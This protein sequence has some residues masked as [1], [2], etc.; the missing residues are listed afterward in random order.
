MINAVGGIIIQEDKIL[1]IKRADHLSFGGFWSNSGGKIE[2][3]ET[4]EQAIVRELFEELGIETEVVQ[5]LCDYH[6]FQEEKLIGIYKG[7]L[8]RI[9]KDEPKNQEP[10]KITGLGWF[11]LKQLPEPIAPYTLKYLNCL[12]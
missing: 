5:F 4:P 9:L 2:Q 1:L 6:D 7:Y 8:L 12:K 11:N 10:D 3:K